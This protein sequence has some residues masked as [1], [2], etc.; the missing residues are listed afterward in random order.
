LFGKLRYLL[1]WQKIT[2]LILIVTFGVLAA[3]DWP[4]DDSMEDGLDALLW[5]TLFVSFI[6]TLRPVTP[7][8][9]SWKVFRSRMHDPIDVDVLLPIMDAAFRRGRGS[10]YRLLVAAASAEPDRLREALPLLNDLERLLVFLQETLP[11]DAKSAIKAGMW[12]LAPSFDVAQFRGWAI[13]FDK[14]HKGFFVGLAD[15]QRE[16]D[17]LSQAILRAQGTA[18]LPVG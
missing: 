5:L 7:R 6:A 18:L 8:S 2:T 13:A 14:G 1:S 15:S 9:T 17:L 16:R 4:L 3:I 11:N 10:V 12:R